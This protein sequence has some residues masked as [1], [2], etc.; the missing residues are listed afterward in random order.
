MKKYRKP[1][2]KRTSLHHRLCRSLGGRNDDRNI[3]VVTANKHR[4]WHS[5][6]NNMSAHE[7]CAVANTIWLDPDY[8]FICI[9]R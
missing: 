5:L 1:P 4:A 7:I 6:F 9:R 3:S 8:R 2:R